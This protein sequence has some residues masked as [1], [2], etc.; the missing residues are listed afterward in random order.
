MRLEGIS[1]DQLVQ[2]CNIQSRV[3]YSRLFRIHVW[4]RFEYFKG[5]RLSNLSLQA[6]CLV[7]SHTHS[8]FLLVFNHIRIS[9]WGQGIQGRFHFSSCQIGSHHTRTGKASPSS[10]SQIDYPTP[11][12]ATTVWV[13]IGFQDI[14]TGSFCLTRLW[15]PNIYTRSHGESPVSPM[16]FTG[17]LAVTTFLFHSLLYHSSSLTLIQSSTTIP[18]SHMD[19]DFSRDSAI[20]CSPEQIPMHIRLKNT[21]GAL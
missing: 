10:W 17:V 6:P 12:H 18:Q 13:C 20:Y 5:W 11:Q 21:H 9:E 3:R 1:D 2:P 8:K 15:T 7:F 16:T 19:Q 4:S 14:R